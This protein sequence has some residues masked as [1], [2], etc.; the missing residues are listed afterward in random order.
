M[1]PYSVNAVGFEADWKL[2]RR[3]GNAAETRPGIS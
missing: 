3:N 2:I 1:T